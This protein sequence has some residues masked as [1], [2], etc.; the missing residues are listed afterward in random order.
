MGAS[1]C[2]PL[3]AVLLAEGSGITV[4]DHF[5][6][7]AQYEVGDGRGRVLV[8]ARDD[9]AIGLQGE[10]DAGVAQA[11]ADHFGRDPGLEGCGGVAVAHVMQ[12]DPR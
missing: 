11:F 2:G 1:L 8:H 9:M 6:V 12:A 5:W 3:L 4:P 10:G 7:L